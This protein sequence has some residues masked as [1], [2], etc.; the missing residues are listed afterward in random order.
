MPKRVKKSLGEMLLDKNIITQEQLDAAKVQ[1]KSGKSLRQA[2]IETGIIT[3]EDMVEFISQHMD[4]PRMELSNYLID[5]TVID[6][7]PEEIARKHQLIPVLKIGNNLTCAMVDVFNVYALDEIT[8]ETGLSVEAAISTEEEINKALDTHYT[9]RGSLSDVIKELG[10]EAKNSVSSDADIEINRLKGMS[11][12]PPMI[13]IVNM[14]I[15]DA[16]QKEASDIHMEPEEKSLK[17]RFRID[18][19]LHEQDSLPKHFQAAIISRIK[20][21]ASLDISERRRPQDGR[22][23]VSMGKR[24]VDIRVSSMPMIYGENI[25]MRL[26]NTDNVLINIEDIGLPQN[27]LD[28]YKKILE[29]QSGIILVT[30]PTGSGKTTTLYASLNIL[31][32]PEKNII[33]IEDPVEYRLKGIRQVQINQAVDLSFATGLRSILR[34]DPDIIMVGEIRDLETAEV[35]TRAALTGHLVLA[36][37]HTNDAIGAIVRMIDIG[38]EPF[39]VSSSFIGVLAQR[40]VRLICQPCKGKGCDLCHNLGYKGRTGIYELLVIND[41]IRRL[42]TNKA[43]AQEI[44]QA[45]LNAGMTMLRENGMQKVNSGETS[46]EEIYRVI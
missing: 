25:V 21:L 3:E 31:N 26:L 35:A 1:T 12:E 24:Q 9:V 7:V 10:E 36:T 5:A 8:L 16:I 42:I 40:L 29:H 28:A 20:I 22:F 23:Q 17:I 30:G 19:I 38:I 11:E 18:G 27:A 44:R 6:L 45:A 46:K 39:L 33:T 41:E 43:S 14:V 32:S 4:I 2:L 34:Q 13:K 37:L 15:M